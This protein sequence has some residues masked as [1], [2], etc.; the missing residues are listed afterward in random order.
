MLGL[1][2]SVVFAWLRENKLVF[3]NKTEA[4]KKAIDMGILKQVIKG[5]YSTMVVTATGVEYIRNNM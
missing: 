4:T 2:R 5:N 1:K 3:Q